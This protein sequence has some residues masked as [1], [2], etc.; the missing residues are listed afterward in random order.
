MSYTFKV[1]PEL[2][3]A[4]LTAAV[5]ALLQILLDFDPSA[6]TD[7]RTWVIAG[8]AAIVRATAAGLLAA[9]AGKATSN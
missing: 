5:V 4:G 8:G 1:G 9:M 3:W 7:L 2:L 6:I